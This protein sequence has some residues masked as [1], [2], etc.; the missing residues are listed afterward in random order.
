MWRDLLIGASDVLKRGDR[1]PDPVI[2]NERSLILADSDLRQVS[3]MANQ[4]HYDFLIEEMVRV[5]QL[6]E[7]IGRLSTD[8]EENE[9]PQMAQEILTQAVTIAV[10]LS[11]WLT[12]FESLYPLPA[13]C[14]PIPANDSSSGIFAQFLEFPNL[15]VAQAMIHCWAAM[16]IVLRCIKICGDIF[17]RITDSPPLPML[18]GIHTPSM[19]THE[20]SSRHSTTAEPE[21][22]ALQFADAI[23]CSVQ[24]CISKDKGAAGPILL[25]PPLWIAKDLY[26]NYANAT[27]RSKEAFVT[28]VYQQLANRGLHFS[29]ALIQLSSR[30][31]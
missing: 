29:A 17:G 31:E 23:C 8:L 30:S 11:D 4:N 3:K 15:L 22:L 28:G 10:S 18:A 6:L 21:A 5:P 2:R 1:K 26:A 24:Y 16:I 14:A 13:T 20:T 12:N 7:Y 9:T 19:A 25:M 27:T